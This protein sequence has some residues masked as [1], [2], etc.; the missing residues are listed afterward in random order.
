M[1]GLGAATNS[2]GP[3][4]GRSGQGVEQTVAPDRVFGQS[5]AQAPE[6][7]VD[8]LE[9]RPCPCSVGIEI[10][11]ANQCREQLAHGGRVRSIVD[12]VPH[13][14]SDGSFWVPRHRLGV[15]GKARLPGASQDVAVVQVAVH[16]AVAV[17]DAR[18]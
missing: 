10:S 7:V 3:G 16:Q 12:A 9:D 17:A 14:F 2:R 13:Q 11:G 6:P 8:G 1:L 4:R 18:S 15:Y 5:G